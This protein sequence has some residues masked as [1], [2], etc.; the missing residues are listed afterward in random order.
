MM[1]RFYKFKKFDIKNIGRHW[2]PGRCY[3]RLCFFS[4]SIPRRWM[5]YK[6]DGIRDC[7]YC[8]LRSWMEGPPNAACD[9]CS[10]LLRIKLNR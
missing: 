7:M 1:I 5:P 9:V 10:D 6:S 8:G 4:I 3:I 2:A